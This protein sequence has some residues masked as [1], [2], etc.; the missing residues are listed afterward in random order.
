MSPRTT[1]CKLL[2]IICEA[3]LENDLVDDLQRLHA[4]GYTIADVRGRGACGVRDAAWPPSASIRVEVLCDERTA[5]NIVVHLER[6][7]YAHYAM[8]LFLG[9]VA[10]LRSGK[11]TS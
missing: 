4:T 7:Y 11:F 2:T 8:V 1:P 6:R 3:Q 9:D 10:V 5:G